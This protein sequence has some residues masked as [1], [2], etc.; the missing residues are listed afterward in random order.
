LKD[1]LGIEDLSD[2]VTRHPIGEDLKECVAQLH[3]VQSEPTAWP[4]VAESIVE[5]GPQGQLSTANFAEG[6][7]NG[8]QQQPVKR[9][10]AL[11]EDCAIP[12]GG[13]VKPV[14][15]RRACGRERKHSMSIIGS[16]RTCGEH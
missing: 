3:W 10:V 16:L 2:P 12:P 15:I 1:S 6:A 11:P 9:R 8:V 5:V 7:P 4:A 13:Q 14:D